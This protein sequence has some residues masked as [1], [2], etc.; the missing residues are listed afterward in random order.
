M[1]SRR[2]PAPA[3]IGNLMKLRD[4]AEAFRRADHVGGS[5]SE[6]K[7]C[8]LD[9]CGRLT[10]LSR[11]GVGTDPGGLHLERLG[12]H[13]QGFGIVNEVV[14]DCSYE[15]SRIGVFV[16]LLSVWCSLRAR[17]VHARLRLGSVA[18]DRQGA[19]QHVSLQLEHVMRGQALRVREC[20]TERVKQV[21]LCVSS[22]SGAGALE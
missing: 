3:I 19:E 21:G 11:A 16:H 2:R 1:R 9:N 22:W 10:E 13:E 17:R 6:L 8:A 7:R 15:K 18:R 14:K 4:D 20:S 12:E 5:L